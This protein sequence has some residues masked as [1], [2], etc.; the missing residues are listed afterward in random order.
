MS[1]SGGS[2]IL[3]LILAML[4]SFIIGLSL[5]I[6]ATYIM[7]VVMV[8]PALVK[9]GMPAHVAHLLAFYFAVLSE[10]SPPVG[11]S[12]SA[13]AAVTGGNP[14]GAMM[15]AWKYSLPAF[16][17]PFLFSATPTGANLLIV[18]ATLSG[19]VVATVTSM[20]ALF[21][22]SIGIV[23]YLYR[24][25]SIPV[26]AVLIIVACIMVLY[27]IGF[28]VLGLLP[29]VIGTLIFVQNRMAFRKC[30]AAGSA[31]A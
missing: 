18:G 9:V 27:P 25:I 3:A 2:P 15:Q 22:L 14:F 28:S 7:T 6:T 21:L 12:P 4:A 10:V 17:V 26:R 8:A 24:V 23:G 31:R 5:P 19:F 30:D 29:I 20:V 13:A 16:L 1:L 11:L